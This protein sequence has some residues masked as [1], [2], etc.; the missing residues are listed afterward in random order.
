L[1]D[2]IFLFE[3]CPQ[4]ATLHLLHVKNSAPGTPAVEPAWI[5][6][7]CQTFNKI[8]VLGEIVAVVRDPAKRG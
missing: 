5:C 4:C 3:A 6:R 2:L 1:S 7:D 8:G